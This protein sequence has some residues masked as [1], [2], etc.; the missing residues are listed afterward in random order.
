VEPRREFLAAFGRAI[1]RARKVRGLSQEAL[2]FEA[3][4]D[5][6]YVSGVERGTRNPTVRVVVRLASALGVRASSLFRS[7]ERGR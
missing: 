4:L 1:R 6:T 2:G 3:E 7:A 5:R